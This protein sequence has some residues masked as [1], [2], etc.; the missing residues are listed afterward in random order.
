V[1]KVENVTLATAKNVVNN[2]SGQG[3]VQINGADAIARVRAWLIDSGYAESVDRV[4]AKGTPDDEAA[5]RSASELPAVRLLSSG[6]PITIAEAKTLFADEDLQ[7]WIDA[8]LLAKEKDRVLPLV[9]I[10]PYRNLF[11]VSDS[12]WADEAASRPDV[13]MGLASSSTWLADFTIR[14]DSDCTLDL[15]TGTGVQAMLASRHSKQVVA[16][17][18]NPRALE[19]ARFNAELNGIDNIEFVEGDMF[20]AVEGRTFDLIVCNPPFSISPASTC[21]YRDNPGDGDGFVKRIIQTAPKYLSSAGFAQILCNWVQ[22]S[23]ESWTDRMSGWLKPTGCNA[24]IVRGKSFSPADYA[25]QWLKGYDTSN[26]EE[27]FGKW[28]SYY[29]QQGIASI[30]GGLITMRQSDRQPNWLRIDADLP[31]IF[32]DAGAHVARCFWLQD[33]L[34]RIPGHDILNEILYLSPS[35]ELTQIS[36]P[37]TAGWQLK[38]CQLTMTRGI[39]YTVRLDPTIARVVAA[40]NGRQQLGRLLQAVA[41]ADGEDL[42]VVVTRYLGALRRLVTLGF[43]WPARHGFEKNFVVAY[44]NS[45]QDVLT[46]GSSAADAVVADMNAQGCDEKEARSA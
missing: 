16:T 33:L 26:G 9:K 28:M 13:V 34:D 1:C 36:K 20:E 25:R 30:D 12:D 5:A 6:S 43:L 37:S 41:I 8:G 19:F 3:S 38:S 32:P 35:V 10:T 29:E 7:I 17:D 23:D 22:S 31:R 15:G 21:L 44:S 18:I 45:T 46:E 4:S 24:W 14:R 40:C 27:L 39:A 2:L 11:I 42:N